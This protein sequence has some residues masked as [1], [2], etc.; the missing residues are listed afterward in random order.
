[1]CAIVNNAIFLALFPQKTNAFDRELDICVVHAA[2]TIRNT[3]K[4]RYGANSM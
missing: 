1:M 2:E 4:T 3:L